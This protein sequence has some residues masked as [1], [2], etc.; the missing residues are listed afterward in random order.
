MMMIVSSLAYHIHICYQKCMCISVA[1]TVEFSAN[2][3]T[4]TE[5]NN[6][7]SIT[8]KVNRLTGMSF[9]VVV[10]VTA[11]TATGMYMYLHHINVYLS[12]IV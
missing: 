2:T 12:K 6:H 1:V 4:V 7:Q 5:S 3:F 11:N 9:N 10:N 8:L